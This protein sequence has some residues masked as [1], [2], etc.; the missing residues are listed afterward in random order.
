MWKHILS[1]CI[2]IATTT[3]AYNSI[4]PSHAQFT[5]MISMGSNP[6][7]NLYGNK[8]LQ[9]NTPN[10]IFS[11]TSG[12]DFIVN[13]AYVNHHYCTISIDGAVVYPDAY[14]VG[15]NIF[16]ESKTTDS[17]FR[18]GQAKLRVPHGSNLELYTSY[19][20]TISC[21]YYAEGYYTQP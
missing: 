20:N 4:R 18:R 15:D 11:N 17:V 8:T 10:T 9:S 16:D 19:T 21:Y 1:L 2:L 3:F 7:V 6:I 13:T 5:P 12:Q 14:T